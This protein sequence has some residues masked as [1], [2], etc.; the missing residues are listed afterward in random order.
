MLQ[1]R[2]LV[3]AQNIA[4]FFMLSFRIKDGLNLFLMGVTNF[5]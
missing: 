3:R 2:T 4:P 5:I 1:A